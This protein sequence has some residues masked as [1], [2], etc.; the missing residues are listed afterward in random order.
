[1]SNSSRKIAVIGIGNPLRKDDGIGIVVLN[2]LCAHYVKTRC[3]ASLQNR[4][5]YFDFGTSSIDLA[6]KL[7]GYKRALLVDGINAGLKPGQLKIFGLKETEAQ[8]IKENLSSTH[9]IDLGQL[10]SLAKS[11]KLDTDI[12]VA[13]IQVEDISFGTALSKTLSD[14]TAS[15]VSQISDFLTF[16]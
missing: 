13:G 9:Q 3:N 6:N 10:L 5:D 2:L 4:Y 7:S 1:M 12:Y 14:N 15:Y 11:L 16:L 8:N